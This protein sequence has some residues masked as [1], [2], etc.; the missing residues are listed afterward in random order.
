M[1]IL[2]KLQMWPIFASL[3]NVAYKTHIVECI[4]C[5][6]QFVEVASVSAGTAATTLQICMELTWSLQ[7]IRCFPGVGGGQLCIW[8][9][10]SFYPKADVMV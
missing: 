2:L 7:P 1:V 4:G 8:A 5:F 10:C 6:M 9:V 3:I